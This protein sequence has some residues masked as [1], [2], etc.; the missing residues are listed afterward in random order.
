MLVRFSEIVGRQ[1]WTAEHVVVHGG[2]NLADADVVPM[3]VVFSE[4]ANAF[5]RIE[6]HIFVPAVSD[7]VDLRAAPLEPDDFVVG[8]A[9]LAARAKRN[10]GPDI[11]G[12]DFELLEDGQVGI[13]GVEDT[14][15]ARAHDGFSLAE[16]TQN[17]GCAALRTIQRL[18]LRFGRPG[19]WR[20][21]RAH[22]QPS[23]LRKF[24]NLRSSNSTNSP[25]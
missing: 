4:V 9:E 23:K 8:T 13:F 25:R 14:M 21:A 16:R 5:V 12:F 11:T 6:Q 24:F 19:E 7:S 2:Q 22:F 20:S 3:A 1:R 15:T 10:E 17:N 18:R